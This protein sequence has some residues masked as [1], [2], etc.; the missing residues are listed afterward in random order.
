MTWAYRHPLGG[1]HLIASSGEQ[2]LALVE[3]SH[4]YA[5]GI[6]VFCAETGEEWVSDADEVRL[7]SMACRSVGSR[8]SDPTPNGTYTKPE[9]M[10]RP[11]A[12]PN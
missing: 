10:Y 6:R 8:N 1:G 12:V 4:G 5:S 7:V 2:A 3:F 9:A 11:R